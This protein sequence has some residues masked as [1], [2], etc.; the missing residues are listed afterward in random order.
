MSAISKLNSRARK[1]RIGESE[2]VEKSF[3][4]PARAQHLRLGRRPECKLC[5]PSVLPAAGINHDVTKAPRLECNGVD[6]APK[7]LVK[8][9]SSTD[10]ALLKQRDAYL[11]PNGRPHYAIH[12]GP[13]L[14]CFT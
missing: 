6:N 13:D 12:S 11:H 2:Q 4:P 5:R 14:G 8:P 10:E 1:A 3:R 7:G 9:F